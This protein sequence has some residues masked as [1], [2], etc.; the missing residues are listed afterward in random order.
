MR[1]VQIAESILSLVTSRDRALSTAGDLT[2]QAAVR[3]VSWFWSS[4]LRTAGSYVWQTFTES[5]LNL[6][7]VAFVGFVV[8]LFGTS[9]MGAI[10]GLAFYFISLHDPVGSTGWIIM[11]NVLA[12]LS[13]LWI[14]RLFARWVPDRE[15]AACL[16]Y[17]I[18]SSIFIF[19]GSLFLNL[20]FAAGL[21]LLDELWSFLIGAVQ[22]LPVLMGAIW[23][24]RRR[25]AAI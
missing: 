18:V 23:G 7:A 22:A 13:S 10:T 2:E 8:G 15:L 4:V 17:V 25:R 9:V 3:G 1:N 16:A 20:K 19:F 21:H 12:L 6:T 11:V 24:R 14:G 5:P